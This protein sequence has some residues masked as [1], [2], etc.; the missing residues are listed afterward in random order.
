MHDSDGNITP[1]FKAQAEELVVRIGAVC[2][3]FPPALVLFVLEAALIEQ[4][5]MF[6][7]PLSDLFVEAMRVYKEKAA[8]LI[9]VAE[10]LKGKAEAIRNGASIEDL[11]AELGIAPESKPQE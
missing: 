7:P 4:I 8:I 9:T 11:L 2:K 10:L 6:S 3:D 1:E 5:S